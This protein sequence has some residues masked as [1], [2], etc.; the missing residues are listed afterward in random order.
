MSQLSKTSLRTA[1]LF[2]LILSLICQAFTVR[3]AATHDGNSRLVPAHVLQVSKWGS[4]DLEPKR[5]QPKKRPVN[6]RRAALDA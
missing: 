6:V 4:G 1:R 2:V 3:P 5:Q